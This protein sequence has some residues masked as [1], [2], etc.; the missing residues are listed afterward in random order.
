M[1]VVAPLGLELDPLDGLRLVVDVGDL[2]LGV[3]DPL[4]LG[5]NPP[6]ALLGLRYVGA[7][8]L[9]PLLLVAGLVYTVGLLDSD[10]GLME[11]FW[12]SHL[13]SHLL[14]SLDLILEHSLCLGDGGALG[15]ALAH[16]LG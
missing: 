5:I 11:H 12:M 10:K 14:E 16:L 1:D 15:P 7:L 8:E 3:V 13:L 2:I 4:E 6:D 9:D